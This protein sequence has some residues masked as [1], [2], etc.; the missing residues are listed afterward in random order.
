M[1]PNK[2]CNPIKYAFGHPQIAQARKHVKAAITPLVKSFFQE[3]RSRYQ[4]ALLFTKYLTLRLFYCSFS[5]YTFNYHRIDLIH[6]EKPCS[7]F[8]TYAVKGKQPCHVIAEE[9]NLQK[10]QIDEH[11]DLNSAHYK[12]SLS[13]RQVT[14]KEELSTWSR[15][16]QT[17]LSCLKI[18]EPSDTFQLVR[19]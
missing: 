3:C 15:S 19:L 10:F 7:H 4:C 17:I 9:N 12:L 13:T 14:R 18:L 11:C 2:L 1:R 6:P 8:G 5:D 16:Y